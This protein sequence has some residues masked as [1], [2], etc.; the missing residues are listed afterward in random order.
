MEIIA[1]DTEIS[2]RIFF[3]LLPK[4]IFKKVVLL[5]FWKITNVIPMQITNEKIALLGLNNDS[6]SRLI[7]RNANSLLQIKEELDF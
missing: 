2:M 5:P 6:D 1:I 3:K 7:K 4:S